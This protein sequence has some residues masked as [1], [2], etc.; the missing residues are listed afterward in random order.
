MSCYHPL[1]S[2]LHMYNGWG[3]WSMYLQGQRKIYLRQTF[4]L[5]RYDI[6]LH[7]NKPS[8][9]PLSHCHCWILLKVK[10]LHLGDRGGPRSIFTSW[11]FLIEG[12]ASSY[13]ELFSDWKNI[14]LSW[15]YC[16]SNLKIT[17]NYTTRMNFKRD[18]PKINLKIYLLLQIL[19]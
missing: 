3:R 15:S 19:S 6:R 9:N 14:V 17:Y 2:W 7:D 16:I 13:Q 8:A 4:A 12:D 5:A 1:M 11:L 10:R 18:F